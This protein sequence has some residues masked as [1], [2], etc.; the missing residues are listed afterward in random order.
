[1]SGPFRIGHEVL[2]LVDAV[3]V[4]PIFQEQVGLLVSGHE[5]EI[6]LD[7]PADDLTLLV[8]QLMEPCAIRVVD[9]EQDL[10]PQGIRVERMRVAIFFSYFL[11]SSPDFQRGK[12]GDERYGDGIGL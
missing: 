10:I 1:M 2:D 7:D 5:R 8:D 4:V 3:E 12:M 6:A 9:S 11:G